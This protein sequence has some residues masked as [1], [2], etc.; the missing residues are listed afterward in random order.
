MDSYRKSVGVDR[1][2]LTSFGTKDAIFKNGHEGT[3]III[4]N[5]SLI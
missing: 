2:P 1:S 5:L 3:E 4:L